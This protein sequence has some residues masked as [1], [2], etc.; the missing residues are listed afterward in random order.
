MAE[1][2]P[3]ANFVWFEGL[4]CGTFAGVE[5]DRYQKDLPLAK[6]SSPEVLVAYAMNGEPL[7]RER[8]GPVR[9][10]VPGW[11]GTNSTKW[12]CRLSIQQGRA[13]GPY[14]TQFYNIEDPDDPNCRPVPVWAVDVNSIITKPSPEKAEKGPH[15]AIEGWAWSHDGVVRVEISLDN[16]DSWLDTQVEPRKE[17][18]WQK[19][20]STV[21]LRS[22]GYL[23][24]A[25]ATSLGKRRQ[26]LVK[27]RNHVHAVQ[28]C[29]E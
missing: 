28:F 26:P 5:A 23:I 27:R 2:T 20:R 19:F 24:V 29:V 15:V 18:S 10:V 7:G 17:F 22:G 21:V 11:F 6:A 25:R 13:P 9:L 16:G 1:P 8:G 3:A 14:T 4:D 12:L